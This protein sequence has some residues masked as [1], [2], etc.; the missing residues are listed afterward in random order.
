MKIALT[1]RRFSEN[2]LFLN[3]EIKIISYSLN[4]IAREIRDILI[5]FFIFVM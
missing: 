2:L 5:S 4:V 3:Y 1:I